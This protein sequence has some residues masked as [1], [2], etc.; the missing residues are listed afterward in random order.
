[1]RSIL[2]KT[3]GFTQG[4]L[5]YSDFHTMG[6][7]N[8]IYNQGIIGVGH[9]DRQ[10]AMNVVYSKSVNLYHILLVRKEATF[11]V[12][13]YTVAVCT[14]LLCKSTVNTVLTWLQL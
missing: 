4:I 2:T 10:L 7:S 13:A 12:V 1:M 3:F 5:A 6:N 14:Q 11:S 9:S 8:N